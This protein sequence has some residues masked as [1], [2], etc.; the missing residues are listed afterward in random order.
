VVK[1]ASPPVHDLERGAH[2]SHLPGVPAQT[3][4]GGE[5]LLSARSLLRSRRHRWNSVHAGGA[6][7]RTKTTPGGF[8]SARVAASP[9]STFF[10]AVLEPPVSSHLSPSRL[11]HHTAASVR[12]RCQ[13]CQTQM[14]ATHIVGSRSGGCMQP[15][16][17][18]VQAGG[19]RRLPHTPGRIWASPRWI[20]PNPV[21][22]AQSPSFLFL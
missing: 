1:S 15:V 16:P 12:S 2:P 7:T 21:V 14:G 8:H 22:S 3:G 11:H 9:S 17:R 13:C 10:S 6:S 4:R 5:P 20:C 19:C 18:M